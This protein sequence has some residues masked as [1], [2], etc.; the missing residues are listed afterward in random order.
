MSSNSI[1]AS[2]SPI[3]LGGLSER[4]D[5]IITLLKLNNQIINSMAANLDLIKAQVAINTQ[6]EASA[7]ALIQQLAL[8]LADASANALDPVE[9][10]AIADQLAVSA[11]ALQAAIDANT[12]P[13]TPSV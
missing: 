1:G 5:A 11:A 12:T 4:L 9:V 7:L 3:L 6:V 2:F 13:T 10:K 8:R